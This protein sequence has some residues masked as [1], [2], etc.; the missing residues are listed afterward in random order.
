MIVLAL[1]N[2]LS[3]GTR[4][5]KSS[6]VTALGAA[7]IVTLGASSAAQAAI[8]D[9]SGD[10]LDGSIT[11]TGTSLDVSTELN[12]DSATFLVLIVGAG[13][14]S[15]LAPDDGFTLSPA[16]SDIIY[17]SGTGPTPLG[18]D[19]IV[20][21]SAGAVTFTETLTSAL[22]ITRATNEIDLTLSGEL[23]DTGGVFTDSPVLLMLSFS[24]PEGPLG[25][26]RATFATMSGGVPAVPELS[27]WAM[28]A[29][30]FGGLGYAASRRRKANISALAAQSL[31][32]CAAKA[33]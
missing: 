15:G 1:R 30:G 25:D 26:I 20:S 2:R 6:V 24:Q 5:M 3:W 21:W 9:F 12:L 7:L 23:S 18:A 10:V 14:A 17:G 13:D 27:T 31:L 11:Y 19:V 32:T 8:V 4:S 16:T 33:A 29:F 28:M 22:S